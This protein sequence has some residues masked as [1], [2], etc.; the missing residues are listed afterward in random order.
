MIKVNLADGSTV[1]LDLE[2]QQDFAKWLKLQNGKSKNIT[3]IAVHKGD[4]LLTLPK[5]KLNAKRFYFGADLLFDPKKGSVAGERIWYQADRIRVA[6][7]VYK[8]NVTRVD[9]QEVGT[10]RFRPKATFRG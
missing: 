2:Q 8:G 9:V 4:L 5:P 10:P 3:G 7:T 1:S 6:L